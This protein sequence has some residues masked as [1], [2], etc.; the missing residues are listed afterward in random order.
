VNLNNLSFW[1]SPLSHELFVGTQ[2]N[3]VASAKREITGLMIHGIV[4]LMR[5]RELP[6]VEVTQDGKRYRLSLQE[7]EA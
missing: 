5:A 4:E 2:K 7:A 3:G 6:F 1:V